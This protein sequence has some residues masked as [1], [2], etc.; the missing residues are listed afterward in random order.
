MRRV[1][2]QRWVQ[3][4]LRRDPLRKQPSASIIRLVSQLS[5]MQSQSVWLPS[6]GTPVLPS[7]TPGINNGRARLSG[8]PAPA[9][10]GPQSSKNR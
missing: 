2:E 10:P 8:A 1:A 3:D 4:E 9:R 6:L 5:L 7:D